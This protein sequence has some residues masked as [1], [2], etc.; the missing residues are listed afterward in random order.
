VGGTVVFDGRFDAA[1]AV[2]TIAD[3]RCN[4]VLAVPTM[5]NRLMAL[6]ESELIKISK[7][8]LRIVASGGARLDPQLVS[9]LQQRFGPVLHNLYGATEASYIT[10]AT[11]TDLLADPACAGRPPLGVDVAI[12]RGGEILPNSQTGDIYVRS[13][14]QVSRYTDGSTKETFRGMIKTGDTGHF[15]SDGRLVVEGRSDGMIVSGGENVFLEQV[16]MVLARSA[17]I[18][19]AK[20]VAVPDADFGQRLVAVVSPAFDGKVDIDDLRRHVAN[21]LSRA[22]V[23]RQFIV[24]PEIPRTATGKV[25]KAMLDELVENASQ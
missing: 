17:S 3:E 4:V 2:Q 16:E 6:D 13:A 1:A 10:I 7:D 22:C 11:P 5:L 23:P 19:D 12:V 9:G 18:Q 20:V 14:S 15:D 24:V 21:E 8:Q 25:S